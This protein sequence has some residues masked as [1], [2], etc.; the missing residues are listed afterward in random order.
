MNGK[1]TYDSILEAAKAEEDPK[2]RTKWIIEILDM[3]CSN[4]LPH[5]E[6]EVSGLKGYMRKVNKKLTWALVVGGVLALFLLLTHP[7]LFNV[8]KV[9]K[10]V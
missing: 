8:F 3:V 4:H 7:E 1:D 10:G 5:I 6:G 2:Q 9:I